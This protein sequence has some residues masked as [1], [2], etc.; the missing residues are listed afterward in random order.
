MTMMV[1]MKMKLL[2][3]MMMT[4]VVARKVRAAWSEASPGDATRS[5]R[6]HLRREHCPFAGT[7]A[8]RVR[9]SN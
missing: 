7:G 1:K 8:Q 9:E 4:V 5:V 2:M 6:R 3:M